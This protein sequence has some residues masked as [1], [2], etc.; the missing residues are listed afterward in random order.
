MV[1]LGAAKNIT[2]RAFTRIPASGAES[3]GHRIPVC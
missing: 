3:L 1:R 2:R